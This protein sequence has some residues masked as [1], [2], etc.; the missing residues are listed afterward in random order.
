MREK[1]PIDDNDREEIAHRLAPM[2]KN[3]VVSGGAYTTLLDAH[4]S[5]AD[6]DNKFEVTP[7]VIDSGM[8]KAAGLIIIVTS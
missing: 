8:E 2:L 3:A 4:K 7:A 1:I 5:L 6:L